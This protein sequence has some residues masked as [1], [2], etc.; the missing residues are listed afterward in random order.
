MPELATDIGLQY[1]TGTNQSGSTIGRGLR[2]S[3][4]ATGLITLAG[5][6]LRGD[7]VTLQDIANNDVGLIASLGGG[8]KCPAVASVAVAQGDVAQ[9]AANGQFA[10]A[11]AAPHCGRWTTAVSGA[12][13]LGEVELE[14]VV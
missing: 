2:V 8:G 6:G 10:G 1:R 4:G 9:A 14:S 7:Y 3:Y 11:G 13:V 5:V 12:G